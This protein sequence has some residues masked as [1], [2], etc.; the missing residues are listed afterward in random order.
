VE[1]CASYFREMFRSMALQHNEDPDDPAG[2]DGVTCV[3][4]VPAHFDRL[5]KDA[6]LRA[7]VMAGLPED[8]VVIIDE[9]VAAA[10]AYLSGLGPSR[11]DEEDIIVIDVGGG[12]T[13]FTVLKYRRNDVRK[14]DRMV[15]LY[16]VECV[17]GD[18]HLGG[19]DFDAVVAGMIEGRVSELIAGGVSVTMPSKDELRTMANAVRVQ[20]TGDEAGVFCLQP[21]SSVH[22]I[23][24]PDFEAAAQ[25]LVDRM[26][27]KLELL[28]GRY[29]DSTGRPLKATHVILAGGASRMPLVRGLAERFFPGVDTP[30]LDKC[31]SVVSL[32][33]AVYARSLITA[34]DM[35]VR[36]VLPRYIGMLVD[37][38]RGDVE[39]MQLVR[40]N[41][42]L[43]LTVFYPDEEGM[44]TPMDAPGPGAAPLPRHGFVAPPGEGEVEFVIEIVEG[45]NIG[46]NSGDSYKTVGELQM[47]CA[48]NTVLEIILHVDGLGKLSFQAQ[49]ADG[50]N[51]VEAHFSLAHRAD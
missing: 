26:S 42:A 37:G 13:D 21:D 51:K 22:E 41:S 47:T 28:L 14:V 49:T 4:T 7:A 23:S 6:T 1:V 38:R 8:K 11:K 17:E 44:S 50:T 31:Q 34:G 46:D 39:M 18:A 12:T 32:G 15:D 25:P 36:Q 24:R 33:A 30:K 3:V 10:I 20:L 27:R 2:L 29:A 43:P 9:P 48:A 16:Q 5:Q 35:V 45:A 19:N 40:A